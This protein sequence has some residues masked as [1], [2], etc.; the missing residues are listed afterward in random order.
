[1]GDL[2]GPVLG[3]KALLLSSEALTW[4]QGNWWQ[5]PGVCCPIPERSEEVR[6]E[7]GEVVA[8]EPVVFITLECSGV[9]LPIAERILFP[10]IP[11][12]TVM[13]IKKNPFKQERSK[14]GGKGIT[15]HGM[16]QTYNTKNMTNIQSYRKQKKYIKR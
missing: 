14:T 5:P 6:D 9:C 8:P 10:F 13:E 7:D 11:V 3:F 12:G 1:M 4:A 15:A 2:A 16:L